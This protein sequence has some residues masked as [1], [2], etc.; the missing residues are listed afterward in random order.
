[1][2]YVFF[3]IA[4]Y[5]NFE[6]NVFHCSDDVDMD[7]RDDGKIFTRRVFTIFEPD[8]DAIFYVKINMYLELKCIF[9]TRF[10]VF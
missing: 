9:L 10:Q 2:E 3:C 6:S 5:S 8:N 7:G 1:M 4:A